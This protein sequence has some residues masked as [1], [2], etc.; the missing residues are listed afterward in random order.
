MLKHIFHLDYIDET[1]N[2]KPTAPCVI[3]KDRRNLE[4]SFEISGFSE[5]FTK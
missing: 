2:Y 5:I 4:Q 3:N 1:P